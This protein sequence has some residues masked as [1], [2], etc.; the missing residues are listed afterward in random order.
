MAL[1]ALYQCDVTGESRE[2]ALASSRDLL[3]GLRLE[4][5]HEASGGMLA[6]QRRH[7]TEARAAEAADFAD[8]LTRAALDHVGELDQI[9][10]EFAEGWSLERMPGIDRNILRLALAEIIHFD[11]IPIGVSIDEA[12]ELAKQY[13]TEESGTFVNGILGAFVRSRGL[14]PID[15]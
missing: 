4:Q 14:A 12:V 1:S 6:T 7:V 8:A 5:E 15:R 2:P 3:V 10:S 9:I 13:S 11:E